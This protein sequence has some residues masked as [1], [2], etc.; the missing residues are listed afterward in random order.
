MVE[1]GFDLYGDGTEATKGQLN[2]FIDI[3]DG[4]NGVPLKLVNQL[5]L[6]PKLGNQ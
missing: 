2:C 1:L 3:Y 6:G 5:N 4:L